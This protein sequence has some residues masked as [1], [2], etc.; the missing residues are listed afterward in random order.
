[1]PTMTPLQHRIARAE[2]REI[3]RHADASRPRMNHRGTGAADLGRNLRDRHPEIFAKPE[4]A[5][6]QRPRLV[7]YR[8]QPE[9]ALVPPE[10][11]YGLRGM[12][13]ALLALAFGPM[14]APRGR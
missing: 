5:E 6:P 9:R 1:M 13:T 2:K 12:A 11:R 8:P 7:S 4:Q 3:R 10:R 14:F